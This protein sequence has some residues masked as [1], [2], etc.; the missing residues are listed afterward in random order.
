MVPN[1]L[2]F[3]NISFLVRSSFVFRYILVEIDVLYHKAMAGTHLTYIICILIN[4]F[5]E[6][7][8][9]ISAPGPVQNLRVLNETMTPSFATIRWDEPSIKNGIITRYTLSYAG[10]RSVCININLLSIQQS[11]PTYWGYSTHIWETLRTLMLSCCLEESYDNKDGN[12][13]LT[14]R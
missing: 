3:T 12:F 1:V 14:Q 2:I 9:I 7:F 11:H 8:K 4:R 6:I 5:D 10:V 13:E